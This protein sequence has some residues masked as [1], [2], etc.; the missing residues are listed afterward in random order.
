MGVAW[1]QVRRMKDGASTYRVAWRGPGGR[2]SKINYSSSF[3]TWDEADRYL[4]VLEG[5]H[6]QGKFNDPSLAR[7]PFEIYAEQWYR[8]LTV[9]PVTRAKYRSYLDSQ[10]LPR[11]TGRRIGSIT[12]AEVREWVAAMPLRPASVRSI[13]TTFS[14]IMRRAAADGYL[15][16][17]SPADKGLVPLPRDLEDRRQ[18]LT[19]EEV[20]HLLD[21]CLSVSPADWPLVYVAVHTGMRVGELFGLSRRDVHPTHLDVHQSLKRTGEVGGT[22]TNRRRRVD[23]D[24]E[25]HRVLMLQLGAH[26]SDLVFPG[27]GGGLVNVDNWRKRNWEP[28]RVAAGFPRLHFHDLRH[29]H[30]THMLA[31]GMPA[32]DLA[33]RL[34]HRS[35]T[36]TW[37]LYGHVV[38]GHQAQGLAAYRA[39]LDRASRFE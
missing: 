15:P 38:P 13:F 39:Y 20:Q 28:I 18:F 32:K 8:T 6:A 5:E 31:A 35:T 21:T 2:Q 30:A 19:L 9:S 16:R 25:L 1:I 27:S 14:S 24:A 23:I 26:D 11:W 33:E 12:S 17:G 34:G 29:T 4:A 7:T 22:K 10:I 37:D 36:M 3:D